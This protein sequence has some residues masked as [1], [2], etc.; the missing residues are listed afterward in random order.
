MTKLM[1]FAIVGFSLIA[2][3][4]IGLVLFEDMLRKKDEPDEH[5]PY[6]DQEDYGRK[7]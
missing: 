7:L 2:F 4:V 5:D 6:A 3:M 1:I